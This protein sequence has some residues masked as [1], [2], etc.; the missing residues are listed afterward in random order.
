M[1]ML[2]IQGCRIEELDHPVVPAVGTLVFLRDD[3]VGHVVRQV[4]HTLYCD[5]YGQTRPVSV[6]LEL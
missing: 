1:K 3:E 2:F 4:Y 6:E 5:S